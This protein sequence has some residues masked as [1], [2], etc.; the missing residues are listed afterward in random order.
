M[1]CVHACA[2]VLLVY[3]RQARPFHGARRRVCACW[4][5][6][7]QRVPLFCKPNCLTQ[8]P[9]AGRRNRQATMYCLPPWRPG[10]YSCPC[11]AARSVSCASSNLYFTHSARACLRDCH[12]CVRGARMSSTQSTR[13]GRRSHAHTKPALRPGSAAAVA[14]CPPAAGYSLLGTPDSRRMTLA[15]HR[16][17]WRATLRR[18][19]HASAALLLAGGLTGAAAVTARLRPA[20]LGHCCLTDERR[21]GMAGAA[22]S[23][24]L[25]LVRLLLPPLLL[26]AVRAAMRLRRC[27]ESDSECRAPAVALITLL[28]RR[29][30]A[31]DW[32]RRR[33]AT[34]CFATATAVPSSLR[35]LELERRRLLSFML[36]RSVDGRSRQLA[37]SQLARCC[38][39]PCWPC[40]S[41]CPCICCAP[42]RRCFMSASTACATS[43]TWQRDVK[44]CCCRRVALL[45][46]GACARTHQR[47][48]GRQAGRARASKHA[49]EH[50]HS[51]CRTQ[52]QRTLTPACRLCRT[53]RRGPYIP[54]GRSKSGRPGHAAACAAARSDAD[55]RRGGGGMQHAA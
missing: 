39:W 47:S 24:L 35:L 34:S 3:T 28:L 21:R 32:R 13:H 38:C 1:R 2:G 6:T 25:P 19:A 14:P 22:A 46:G 36:Q 51:S 40:C 52:R 16:S 10:V 7:Q 23:L 27:W 26:S 29:V 8:R 4:G 11:D 50:S 53:L 18:R 55:C 54:A 41:W 45:R 20:T 44:R 30:A 33:A 31:A 49:C 17:S 9:A 43:A 15:H 48:V 5:W 37:R 42:A 12:L